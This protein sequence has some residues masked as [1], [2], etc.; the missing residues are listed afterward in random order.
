MPI[1]FETQ[2]EGCLINILRGKLSGK[3]L[4]KN[5]FKFKIEKP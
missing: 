3:P 5:I 1:T 2:Q 4:E